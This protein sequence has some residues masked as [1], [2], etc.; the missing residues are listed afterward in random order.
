MIHNKKAGIILYLRGLG[1]LMAAIIVI[2]LFNFGTQTTEGELIN[3]NYLARDLALT[4]TTIASS[5]SNTTYNYEEITLEKYEIVI[6]VEEQQIIVGDEKGRER[7]GFGLFKGQKIRI[8]E[9][10]RGSQVYFS[11]Q[12]NEILIQSGNIAEVTDE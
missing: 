2:V 4:L 9:S 5:P 1:I 11:K 8:V 7:Y 3:K 10:G 12:G 6:D